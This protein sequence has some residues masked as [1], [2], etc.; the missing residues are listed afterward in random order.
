MQT[1]RA[2]KTTDYRDRLS[3]VTRSPKKPQSLLHMPC[4]AKDHEHTYHQLARTRSTKREKHASLLCVG[5][6]PPFRPAMPGQTVAAR[7]ATGIP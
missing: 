4:S 3:S 5:R 7:Y 6:R 2:P 1:D